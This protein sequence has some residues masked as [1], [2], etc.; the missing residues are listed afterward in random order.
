MSMTRVKSEAEIAAMRES[1]AMLKQVLDTLVA[2]LEPG[3]N[4]V[5][6]DQ[7]ARQELKGL[8]GKPAFFGYQGFPGA[9]C[10]SVNDE[11]VHGT[12]RNI[13]LN[14]GDLLGM[15]FG[16]NYRG[17]ITDSARTVGIGS[18][19]KQHQRLLDVTERSMYAGIDALKDGVHVG[20]ISAAVEAVLAPE[21]VG[22]I[23][24]LVG[25]GVG[26]ELHEEPNIPNF[27]TRGEGPTLK[28]G[29]TVCIEPMATLSG[30]AIAIDAEDKWTIRTTDGS[31][32]AHFEHTILVFDLHD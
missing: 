15:D 25:H 32:A 31:I 14:E 11:V 7:M 3:M 18:V 28:S 26:H 17:M 23:R 12:P 6:L 22:I 30:D 16:V 10:L 13:A 1:G 4:L 21:N 29:M 27:G 19:S 9:I 8:G 2:S 24:D 20:D 5:E